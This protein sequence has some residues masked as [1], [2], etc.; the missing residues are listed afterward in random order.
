MSILLRFLEVKITRSGSLFDSGVLRHS[1]LTRDVFLILFRLIFFVPFLLTFSSCHEPWAS[2]KITVTTTSQTPGTRHMYAICIHNRGMF[3]R[4]SLIKHFIS[5]TFVPSRCCCSPVQRLSAESREKIASVRVRQVLYTYLG[6]GRNG[7]YHLVSLA[8]SQQFRGP[9]NMRV[10]V[11]EG[12][13]ESH[14]TR[15]EG[16][17]AR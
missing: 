12:E 2:A 5:L 4:A 7:P 1:S 14:G 11:C 17:S 8:A 13:G 9:E 3:Q 10:C 15:S 16:N 6:N